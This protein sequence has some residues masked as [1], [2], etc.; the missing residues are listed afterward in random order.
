M[1]EPNREVGVAKNEQHAK[2]PRTPEGGGPHGTVVL[3][4]DELPNRGHP[5]GGGAA[6]DSESPAL[7]GL[8]T[9]FTDR[10]FRL[11]PERS[12][13]GRDPRGD[14]VLDEPDVSHKHAR[15]VRSGGEWRVVDLQSTNG[16]FVNG[17]RVQQNTVRYGDHIAF[18]PASFVFAAGNTSAGAVRA[19]QAI[20]RHP[21]RWWLAA[22]AVLAAVVAVLMFLW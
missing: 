21:R 1:R 16:T 14:V 8:T 5:V 11:R 13:I 15:I 20:G 7:I 18:G 12:R 22:G 10:R 17:R 9:P 6:N 2:H 4:P 3:P 19:M